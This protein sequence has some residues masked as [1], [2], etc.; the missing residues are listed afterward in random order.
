M[1]PLIVFC[2]VLFFPIEDP[3]V[4]LLYRDEFAFWS[5]GEG[6]RLEICYLFDL[7]KILCG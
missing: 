6:Y 4:C 5:F 7:L 1:I 3:L 2:L